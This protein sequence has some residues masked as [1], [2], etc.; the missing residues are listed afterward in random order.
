MQR[1][2][3]GDG[4]QRVAVA[5]DHHDIT[6]VDD[7][8][9]LGQALEQP[10][11]KRNGRAELDPLLGLHP[12]GQRGRGVQRHDP[13]SVD[14]RHPVAQPLGLLHEVGDEHDRD[15]PVAHALDQLP[16]VPPGLRVQAGGQLV[17]HRH[18]WV[19]DEGQRDRQPLL[20][21]A[22]ELAERRPGLGR[23]TQDLH[24][25]PPVSRGLVEGA[26]QLQSLGHPE[27]VGQP[28][29]LQLGP[30]PLGQLGP[31]P[32]RVEPEHADLAA[33]RC[34]QPLDALHG[35][36]LARPVGAEDAEDLPFLNGERDVVHGHRVLVALVQLLHIDY[37]WHDV[38]FPALVVMT[39]SLATPGPRPHRPASHTWPVTG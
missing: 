38:P 18:A 16:G 36:G 24:Q 31:V 39:I 2:H 13:A 11:F 19:A 12:L 28:A 33:I 3:R 5:G 29:F 15:A 8:G 37:R 26:V 35:R 30:E 34:P 21:A 7:A 23:D 20:L 6:P 32:L 9:H 4:V 10:V 22:G 27:P 25:L 17:Q 1:Q 14:Q